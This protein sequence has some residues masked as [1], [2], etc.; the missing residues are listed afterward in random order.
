MRIEAGGPVA[1]AKQTL[2][3]NAAVAACDAADG[4]TDGVLTDPRKCTYNPMNDATI[5]KASCTSADNTCLT[6]GEASAIQ[7]IWTGPVNTKGKSLWVGITRGTALG[8]LAGTNPFA[9][10]VAQPRF[11]VYFDPLWDWM[12]LTYANYEAF[13]K[14]TIRMVNPMMA[15][16]NPDLTAFRDLGGKI[17]MWQGFSDQLIM[18]EGSIAYYDAATNFMGGGY[19]QTQQF[20]RHFMAPGVGHCGGGPGPQPQGL[21]QSV[22]DWVENGVAPETILA[23]RTLPGGGT[24]T[25]PL[26]QYPKVAKYV[27]TGSTDDAA[28]FVCANP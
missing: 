15:S 7:K 12:T 11:W 2:A 1:A 21:F 25:R 14:D 10:A 23:S 9:I 26:C 4:V 8:G 6:P 24:Q 17:V 16:E 13:F 22:V 19:A 28:N 5:T 3:S 27:G 20:F 18:A